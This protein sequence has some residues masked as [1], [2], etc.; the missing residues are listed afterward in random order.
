MVEHLSNSLV[1]QEEKTI[2]NE[3]LPTHPDAIAILSGGIMNR[4]RFGSDWFEP[5]NFAHGLGG[6]ARVIAATELANQF[7]KAKL[8]TLSHVN[9]E[10]PSQ[11]DIYASTLT[12]F[13]VK[14][15][16]IVKD[17]HA[18]NTF[19][20]LVAIHNQAVEQGWQHI[21]VVSNSYHKRAPYM[22]EHLKEIID[23]YHV[24]DPQLIGSV[25]KTLTFI[26]AED[27]LQERNNRYRRLIDQWKESPSYERLLQL[28]A[29]G[30]QDLQNGVYHFSSRSEAVRTG[31]LI[32]NVLTSL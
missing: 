21:Y 1:V 27:L 6:K 10:V 31:I 2:P 4:P 22:I 30:L 26:A 29:K 3:T 11:A 8:L 19:S 32:K 17:S 9:P 25:Q 13:G 18:H 14:P 16:R 24:H 28:E 5:T 7:P 15:E 12:R 23:H 20:E